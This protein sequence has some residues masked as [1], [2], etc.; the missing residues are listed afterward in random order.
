MGIVLIFLTGVFEENIL[1]DRSLVS[2][3]SGSFW[4]MSTAPR[5]YAA[6]YGVKWSSLRPCV[7]LH[8]PPRRIYLYSILYRDWTLSRV[9]VFLPSPLDKL[10]CFA[11][12]AIPLCFLAPPLTVPSSLLFLIVLNLFVALHLPPS[13]SFPRAACFFHLVESI[14]FFRLFYS[15]SPLGD[16]YFFPCNSVPYWCFCVATAAFG[17]LGY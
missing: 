8:S 2:S 13:S 1:S 14:V 4:W 3:G 15:V 12:A 17:A 9:L 7:S 10:C 5:R 6:S 11:A 16:F